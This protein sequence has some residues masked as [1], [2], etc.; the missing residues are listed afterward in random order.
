[1]AEECSFRFLHFN[2]G[3]SVDSVQNNCSSNPSRMQSILTSA[4]S[5][6]DEGAF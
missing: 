5:K 1:M 2:K 6:I 4:Q 3:W